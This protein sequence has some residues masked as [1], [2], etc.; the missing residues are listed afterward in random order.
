MVVAQARGAR[1]RRCGVRAREMVVFFVRQ[2]GIMFVV[3]WRGVVVVRTMWQRVCG[4]C[5]R[6]SAWWSVVA[7][8]L[9]VSRRPKA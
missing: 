3:D 8:P 9:C 6:A 4:V 7:P 1:G 5:E 2:S